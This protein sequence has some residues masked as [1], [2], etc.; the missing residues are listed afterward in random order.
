[1]HAMPRHTSTPWPLRRKAFARRM[2]AKSLQSVI[3]SATGGCKF[4]ATTSL[5]D[6]G[7]HTH[8]SNGNAFYDGFTTALPP[9]TKTAPGG[10]GVNVDMSSIDEDD[11]GPTYSAITSRSYHPGGVNSLFAD[12]SVK[13]VK[14]SV[15]WQTW[16]ALGTVGGNEV[17]SS[18]AY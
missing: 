8:W 9:N 10:T 13:F 6:G 2:A 14:D 16:R 4:A 15:N 12:G 11:G 5:G 17:I 1:M 3:A 18:D 7:G